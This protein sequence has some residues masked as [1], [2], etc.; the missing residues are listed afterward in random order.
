MRAKSNI[1]QNVDWPLVLLYSVLVMLGWANI[2][3]ATHSEEH[4]QIFDLSQSYGKQM[5]WIFISMV[6][7]IILLMIDVRFFDSF[8]Y[9]IY[10]FTVFLLLAVLVVG[11]EIKGA[12]SWFV[13]GGAFSIQPSELAKFATAL[14]FSKLLSSLNVKTQDVKTWL[15]T[16]L[17]ILFPAALIILQPD[18][19][20]A[21]VYGAFILVLYREG[22]SGNI[23]LIA[24]TAVVFFILAILLKQMS[25][26][27]LGL[28]VSG[29]FIFI[30]VLLLIASFAYWI[31]R[32]YKRAL[33]VVSVVLL[34]AM[35]Y[36]LS[37]D[38]IFDNVLQ[39]RHRNRI[40][41]LLGITFDPTG[42]GYNVHQSKI[43]IGSGRFFGK[44]FL[45][46]TQT[47]FNFV[48]E[49]S[50]DFIFCTVGEEWG[51][52]GTSLVIILFLTLLFRLIIM[53]ERQRSKF[54]RIYGYCVA[55]ILFF[56]LAINIGMTIG[57]APVIGIPLPLFS[58]GGSSLWAFTLLL[59]TFIK[60]D[61]E[62]KHVLR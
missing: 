21:L 32:K 60:L 26:E 39:D 28:V 24:L 17:L 36:I 19:G 18:P 45:Q 2:Y 38:Y 13:I 55:S 61:S 35:G 6:M 49:Q 15:V 27:L 11:T 14:A 34:V 40:N 47:K 8:A 7:A 59:F 37:I 58:Y 20:S 57:L 44:G 25:V 23:L 42:T 5:M 4:Y 54:A 12:K 62:R 52:I 10:G 33:M 48:P 46:G 53:A 56:H 9:L 51:F 22:L 43:A 3:A 29:K 30:F 1:F 16:G 31:I 41:D 50:T